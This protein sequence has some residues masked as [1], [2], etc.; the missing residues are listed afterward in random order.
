MTRMSSIRYPEP[1]RAARVT[2][3]GQD[4]RLRWFRA[5]GSVHQHWQTRELVA[6]YS[7]ACDP[8]ALLALQQELEARPNGVAQVLAAVHKETRR[9][10]RLVD[11]ANRRHRLAGKVVARG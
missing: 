4:W 5:A 3:W 6:F 1:P 11:Q 8:A 2:A 9:W 10:N 7:D